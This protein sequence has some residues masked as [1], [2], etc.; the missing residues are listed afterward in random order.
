MPDS[1]L[2]QRLE[3]DVAR[4]AIRDYEAALGMIRYLQG[5]NE[6][7]RQR[8]DCLSRDLTEKSRLLDQERKDGDL[9]RR[10]IEGLREKLRALSTGML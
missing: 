10:K 1:H 5:E 9:M 3:S 8:N 2:F 6:S 4:I 7:L